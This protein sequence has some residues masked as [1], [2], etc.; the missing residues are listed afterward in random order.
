MSQEKIY[1]EEQAIEASTEYFQG[2]EL[3]ANVFVTK[4][5]LRDNDRKLLEKTPEEMHWRIAKEFAR[6]EKKKYKKPLTAEEIYE[7][8]KNFER[9]YQIIKS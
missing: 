5:A 3:A 6:V 1:T 8:L 9:L 7:F 2:N 4:Y